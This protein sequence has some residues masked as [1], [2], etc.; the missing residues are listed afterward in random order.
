[1]GMRCDEDAFKSQF[2]GIQA[3]SI[4]L[5]KSGG[6]SADNEINSVSGASVS[7]GA[8]VNAINGALDFFAANA[9]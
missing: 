8:V 1:M 4:I 7:S 3:D 6:A 9:K 2:T 5:N